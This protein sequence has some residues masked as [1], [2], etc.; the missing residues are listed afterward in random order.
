MQLGQCMDTKATEAEVDTEMAEGKALDISGTP[1]MFINGRRIPN[2]IEWQGLK[3]IID[4]EIEY[5]KTAKNAGDD[6]GC[7]VKLDAP[8]LPSQAPAISPIKKK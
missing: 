5:Q 1:T 2:T 7:E 8:G 3:A 6:C 4:S